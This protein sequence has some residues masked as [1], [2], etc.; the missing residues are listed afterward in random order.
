MLP[1]PAYSGAGGGSNAKPAASGSLAKSTRNTTNK[2]IS[3][4]TKVIKGIPEFC[5]S[6]CIGAGIKAHKKGEAFNRENQLEKKHLS[7]PAPKGSAQQRQN[8][9]TKAQLRQLLELD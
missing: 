2:L 3:K 7:R 9:R 8:E 1:Q 4:I 6:D 5:A